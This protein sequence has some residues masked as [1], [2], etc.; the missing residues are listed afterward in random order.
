MTALTYVYGLVVA[1]RKPSLA[2]MPPGLPGASPMRLL[3]VERGRWLAVADVKA[4]DYGEEAVN[5]RLSNLD[6]VSRAAMAH[7]AALESLTAR[8]TVLPMKLFTIFTNDERALADVRRNRAHIDALVRRVGGH[9]EFGIRVVLDRKR[10]TARRGTKRTTAN[11]VGSGGIAYLTRKKAQRDATS[12]LATHARDTVADLY[13]RLS[14]RARLARRRSASELP[15]EPGPL[16]LDAAFLVPRTKARAFRASVARE[17]RALSRH[18]YGLTL[19]GPWP[20]YTF[21]Q[22]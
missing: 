21:V 1:A 12:E 17:A 8:A 4:R 13:D 10:A 16:L 14:R 3:E 20:P 15:I 11:A 19:T 7:E 22:D 6:W 9:E 5:R 2:R 18:G